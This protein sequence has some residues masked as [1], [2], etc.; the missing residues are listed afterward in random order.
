M[1][2]VGKQ[3]TLPSRLV[4]AADVEYGRLEPPDGPWM[5]PVWDLVGRKGTVRRNATHPCAVANCE[6]ELY[7]LESGLCNAHYQQ[8][9]R[10]GMPK[11]VT[12]WLPLASEPAVRATNRAVVD[13]R[14]VPPAVAQEI[15]FVV[16]TKILAGDWSPNNSLRAVLLALIGAVESTRAESLFERRPEDW[17]LI[18]CQ[19]GRN[20]GNIRAYF[21]TFFATLHRTAC[22]DPWDEDIWL[23]THGFQPLFGKPGGLSKPNIHWERIEQLWL[24]NAL[25]A[26]ARERLTAGTRTWQTVFEWQRHAAYFSEYLAKEGIEGPEDVDRELFL[27]YLQETR[28]A[29]AHKRRLMGVSTVS[30]LLTDL[31]LGGVVPNLGSE[32]YL[33]RGENGVKKSAEPRPFPPDIVD[34]I[35]A[36]LESDE[37]MDPTIRTMLRFNRW[38]GLRISELLPL[39][40]DCLRTNK[41]GKLWAEFFMDKTQDWRKI[42]LP[43]DIAALLRK[44]QD[45]VRRVY[46]HDVAL[47]F[48]SPAR[49]SRFVGVV[50]PWSAAGFRGH[51]AEAFVRNGI[52]MSAVT[53][54]VVR[55]SQIH[56]YRHTIGTQL[57]NNGWTQREVQQ[58]FK[59]ASPTMTAVYAQITDDTLERK[60]D[61]FYESQALERSR[62]TGEPYDD[63]AVEQLRSRIATVLPNGLCTMPQSTG[64]GCDFAKNPCLSCSFFDADP[65]RFG[66]VHANHRRLLQLSVISQAEANPRQ[67]DFNRGILERLD[68]LLPVNEVSA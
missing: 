62:R 38:G 57:L 33:R 17:I 5:A 60:S 10:A 46:G 53:G 8:W 37:I 15:R 13:F 24:R 54:E 25:K 12:G 22:S 19:P 65:Q 35:D 59:H 39:P 41:K 36:M 32:V 16:G 7:V 67:A 58:F 52:H 61:E 66:E 51:V 64:K 45:Q 34:Q 49:S 68:E 11:P 47:M 9:Y 44:Q 14:R 43:D 29:G 40:L 48:P 55:G 23:W 3:H 30:A 27:D 6:L 63:P 31:R 4:G 1:T 26:L 2:L 21:R 20:V 42:P 56:R 18:A 28:E 50:H